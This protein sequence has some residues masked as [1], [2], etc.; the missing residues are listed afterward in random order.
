MDLT[1]STRVN[2]TQL[3]FLSYQFSSRSPS[4]GPSELNPDAF[5]PGFLH[6]VAQGLS[7]CWLGRDRRAAVLM[8]KERMEHKN[9]VKW[10][11]T[12]N[13]FMQGIYSFDKK[14][15]RKRVLFYLFLFFFF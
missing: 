4:L 15:H 8:M 11:S 14:G 6:V 3:R 12:Q 5:K 7:K 2:P 10:I 9:D 13:I 1:Y